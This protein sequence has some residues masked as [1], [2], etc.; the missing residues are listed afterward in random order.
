MLDGSN[1][2][3]VVFFDFWLVGFFFVKC[4]CAKVGVFVIDII[5]VA[6]VIGDGIFV[7]RSQIFSDFY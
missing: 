7:L 4:K 1:Y 3:S 2:N 5:D 6:K